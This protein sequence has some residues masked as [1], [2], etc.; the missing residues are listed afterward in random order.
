M[1]LGMEKPKAVAECLL[2]G[3]REWAVKGFKGQEP[4]STSI[5]PDMDKADQDDHAGRFDELVGRVSHISKDQLDKS[6]SGW[7]SHERRDSGRDEAPGSGGHGDE[8][9]AFG[10]HLVAFLV[11]YSDVFLHEEGV[12][13]GGSALPVDN[14]VEPAAQP[15]GGM[16]VGD[17]K[18]WPEWK[19]VHQQT[20]LAKTVADQAGVVYG[21]HPLYTGDDFGDAEHRF[22]A[23]RAWLNDRPNALFTP[24]EVVVDAMMLT[25]GRNR[26]EIVRCFSGRRLSSVQSFRRFVT[27]DRPGMRGCLHAMGKMSGLISSIGDA[28]EWEHRQVLRISP[29]NPASAT[30]VEIGPGDG[31]AFF[32][33]FQEPLSD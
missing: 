3:Y 33:F 6:L 27:A 26:E 7:P 32:D 20:A 22:K 18:S 19:A 1:G 31:W 25:E 17:P 9:C 14:S 4:R 11:P 10:G 5:D 28:I 13:S 29:K 30:D 21:D 23:I 15:C 12:V 24:P 16:W 2:A 8:R